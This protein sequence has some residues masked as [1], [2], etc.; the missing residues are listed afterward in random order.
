MANQIT[1]NLTKPGEVASKFQLNLR[2]GESFKV[3]LSW[4]GGR[5]IDIHAFVCLG[6]PQ[7][8]KLQAIEDILSTY[9]V[10]RV[11]AGESVGTLP[12][13]ADGTFEV[14]GGALVHSADALDGHRDGD[15]EWMLIHPGRLGVPAG[16]YL[17]I[18]LVAMIHPQENGGQFRDV[19]NAAIVIVNAEGGELMRANLSSQFGEFVGVQMGSIMID[20][21]GKSEFHA[22]GVG[23][24]GDFNSVLAHFC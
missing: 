7:G 8:A 3:R 22:V 18:P 20:A 23:F 14:R 12:K 9:N 10:Q 11:I 6:T 2:K 24:Q 21:Q 4:D 13:K 1:L 15:D 19:R 5:D 17:E 16:S